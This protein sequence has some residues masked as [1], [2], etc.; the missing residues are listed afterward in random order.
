MRVLWCNR[1]A[2]PPLTGSRGEQCL[3]PV[4]SPAC[5]P[6]E[7]RLFV[8]G[9]RRSRGPRSRAPTSSRSPGRFK[10]QGA[11]NARFHVRPPD[12]P[13]DSVNHRNVPPVNSLQSRPDESSG[14]GANPGGVTGSVRRQCPSVCFFERESAR[15]RERGRSRASRL[16]RRSGA[17]RAQNLLLKVDERSP[18]AMNEICRWA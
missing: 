8:A 9:V 2:G 7:S 12:T 14:S 3:Y 16:L 1:C 6:R 15:C 10:H 4:R 18:R 11:R 17:L 5:L 13:G